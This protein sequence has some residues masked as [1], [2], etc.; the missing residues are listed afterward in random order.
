MQVPIEEGGDVWWFSFSIRTVAGHAIRFIDLET[1]RRVCFSILRPAR[2]RAHRAVTVD[3][4][5]PVD[6]R[7]FTHIHVQHI[8]PWIEGPSVPL[9]SSQMSGH[10]DVALEAWGCVD[11][12]G[13]VLSELLQCTLMRLRRDVRQVR[14]R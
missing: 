12:A 10:C 13:T 14:F 7:Y 11:G 8:Q 9:R 2:I 5:E 4:S 1:Q 6:C 3:R